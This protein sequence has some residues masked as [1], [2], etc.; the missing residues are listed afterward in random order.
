MAHYDVIVVRSGFGGSVATLRAVEKGYTVAAL[1]SGHRWADE[2]IP[3]R[4]WRAQARR[5]QAGRHPEYP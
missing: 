4:S 5:E 2:N 3:K 1:E